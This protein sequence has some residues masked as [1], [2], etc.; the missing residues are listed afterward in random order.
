MFDMKAYQTAYYQ[1][2]K[3]RIG[4]RS[5]KHYKENKPAVNVRHNKYYA[6]N[7]VKVQATHKKWRNNNPGENDTLTISL[8]ENC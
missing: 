7:K 8:E 2:N 1:E 4:K 3:E 6:D 5:A